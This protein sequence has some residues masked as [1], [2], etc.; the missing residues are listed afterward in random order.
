MPAMS[1]R[2]PLLFRLEPS[3][4]STLG[5]ADYVYEFERTINAPPDVVLSAMFDGHPLFRAPGCR[6]FDWHT[7]VGEFTDAVVD[8]TFLFMN[9]RMRT[10]HYEPG[11]ALVISIDRCSMPLASSMVQ[12]M[13]VDAVDGGRT[14]FRWRIGVRYRKDTGFM[15][16]MVTP[17]F[18]WLFSTTIKRLERR[19]AGQPA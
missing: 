16:P 14:R 6:R 4:R 1:L 8:E 17:L 7:P 9:I 11:R 15:A 18:R 19:F 12:D 13:E 5:R 3:D 2:W 10:A